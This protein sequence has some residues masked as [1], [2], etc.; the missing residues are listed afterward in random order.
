[1][2]KC[3]GAEERHDQL[4][5]LGTGQ[6]VLIYGHGEEDGQGF[7]YRHRFDHRPTAEEIRDVIVSQ[8]DANTNAKI[9]TGYQWTV[10]HGDTTKPEEQRHVGETVHVW[11]NME[12]QGNYKEAHRLACLDASKVV[13]VKFKISQDSKKNAI[14]ETFETFDELDAF[15]M[16]AFA[17]IKKAL[18][19]GWDEKD[20]ID[21]T[22]F[23]YE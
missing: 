1:M 10:L 3:Y 15:Y 8:I 6:C 13:P 5:V 23:V 14:Y 7:D 11:L 18:D 12:N 16:G 2:E 20:N 21:L 17:F 4:I 22:K 9:L 19:D